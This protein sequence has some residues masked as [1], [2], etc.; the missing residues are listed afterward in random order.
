MV[1]QEGIRVIGREKGAGPNEFGYMDSLSL[2]LFG[3]IHKIL[4]KGLLEKGED[5]E[6]LKLCA[7]TIEKFL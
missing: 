4:L 5:V 6:G 1:F 3:P 2:Y 7:I